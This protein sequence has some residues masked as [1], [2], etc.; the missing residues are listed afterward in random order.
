MWFMISHGKS[1]WGQTKY[2]SLLLKFALYGYWSHHKLKGHMA[3]DILAICP[4]CNF[5]PD[6]EQRIS[7]GKSY[8]RLSNQSVVWCFLFN[9]FCNAFVYSR[10]VL[11][12]RARGKNSVS[13]KNLVSSQSPLSVTVLTSITQEH[14]EIFGFPFF[15]IQDSETLCI[16][17][18]CLEI[19]VSPVF[20]F[21]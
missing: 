1:Q 5:I 9:F 20:A 4:F 17:Q 14:P 15:S 21:R 8:Y 6:V 11:Y 16:S 18:Y 10:I 12:F 3:K 2:P 19:S 13:I 7:V